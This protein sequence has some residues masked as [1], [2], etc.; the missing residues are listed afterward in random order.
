MLIRQVLGGQQN[1]EDEEDGS[2]E[3]S[4]DAS[5]TVDISEDS[6]LDIVFNIIP[7]TVASITGGDQDDYEYVYDEDNKTGMNITTEDP[8]DGGTSIGG[9]TISLHTIDLA[10]MFLNVQQSLVE[11]MA[12]VNC[13]CGQEFLNSENIANATVK[14]IEEEARNYQSRRRMLSKRKIVTRNRI[15]KL[16]NLF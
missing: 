4:G 6:L 10:Q 12:G 13:T 5:F 7:D 2:G 16:L 9:M 11:N 3:G 15:P 14:L 8:S 1:V